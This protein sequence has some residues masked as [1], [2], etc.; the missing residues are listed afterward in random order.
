MFPSSSPSHGAPN[1]LSPDRLISGR[2][3]ITDRVWIYS[4]RFGWATQIHSVHLALVHPTQLSFWPLND[5]LLS[6]SAGTI[7]GVGMRGQFSHIFLDE[8]AQMMEAEALIPFS[9]ATPQTI[10]IMSGDPKQVGSS[11]P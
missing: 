7:F 2:H 6:A 4:C 11:R 9:L 1:H 3:S 10:V 5:V 8:A